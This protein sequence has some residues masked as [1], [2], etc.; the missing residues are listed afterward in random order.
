MNVDIAMS[1]SLESS[2]HV[3]GALEYGGV[4]AFGGVTTKKKDDM[5]FTAKKH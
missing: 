1:Q 4:G 3:T 5:D 2:K